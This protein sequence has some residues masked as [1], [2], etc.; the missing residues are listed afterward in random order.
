[1]NALTLRRPWPGIAAV[2]AR[3]F[4]P[5]T[6]GGVPEILGELIERDMAKWQQV[7]RRA[8]ITAE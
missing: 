7:I 2:M 4:P 8:G 5:I 3:P 6:A 1:M